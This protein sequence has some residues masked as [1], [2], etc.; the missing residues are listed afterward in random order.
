MQE[1]IA[2]YLFERTDRKDG[3]MKKEKAYFEKG[4]EPASFSL[5]FLQLCEG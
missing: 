1:S 2:A 3:G 4:H 5:L